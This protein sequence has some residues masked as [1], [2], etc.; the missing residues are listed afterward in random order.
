MADLLSFTQNLIAYRCSIIFLHRERNEVIKHDR[1]QTAVAHEWR[2]QSSGNKFEH[3][4]KVTTYALIYINEVLHY[5]FVHRKISTLTFGTRHVCLH[6]QVTAVG[7]AFVTLPLWDTDASGLITCQEL[8]FVWK[9]YVSRFYSELVMGCLLWSRRVKHKKGTCKRIQILLKKC[10]I[11]SVNTNRCRRYDLSI[12][13]FC[14]VINYLG[15]TNGI[16]TMVVVLM[17]V[18]MVI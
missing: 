15:I 12:V 11:P 6:R 1:T 8:H 14:C 16:M 10:K 7:T 5:Q 3:A 18:V 17:V 9:C 2:N 4:A 13:R